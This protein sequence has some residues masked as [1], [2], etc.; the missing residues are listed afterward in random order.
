MGRT[1]YSS[2]ILIVV[3]VCFVISSGA[4]AGFMFYTPNGN[5]TGASSATSPQINGWVY[6]VR[7]VPEGA[8]SPFTPWAEPPSLAQ[9]LA[10]QGYSAAN[11]WTINRFSLSGSLTLG[12]YRAWAENSPELAQGSLITKPAQDHLGSG[13]SQIGL[14]Y[15]AAG[16][17]PSGASAH[18]LQIV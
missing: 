1:R 2:C 4:Q 17:D 16:S 12:T 14:G 5:P 15:S 11:G 7:L 6:T 8:S 9:V 18:W 10:A 13:G 3:L